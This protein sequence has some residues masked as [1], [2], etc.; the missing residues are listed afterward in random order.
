[1]GKEEILKTA[2][3]VAGIKSDR[4]IL[5][6]TLQV[7]ARDVNGDAKRLTADNIESIRAGVASLAQLIGVEVDVFAIIFEAPPVTLRDGES[8]RLDQTTTLVKTTPEPVEEVDGVLA[9]TEVEPEFI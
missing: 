9:E 3:T 4:Q 1:M 7:A 6:L 8:L 5:D 2:A